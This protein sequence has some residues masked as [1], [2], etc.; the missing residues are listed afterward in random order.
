MQNE[1][2]TH[3]ISTKRDGTMSPINGMDNREKYFARQNVSLSREVV[4]TNLVHGTNVQIVDE[5]QA[6]T[7]VKET[8]GVITNEKNLHLSV[9]AGDCLPLFFTDM[10]NRVIGIAHAGWRGVV[11]EIALKVVDTMQK[12]FGT[13]P[14]N[15]QILIGPHIKQCHFEVQEDIIGLFSDYPEAIIH[16]KKGTH[17]NLAMIVMRQLLERGVK[18]GNMKVSSSCTYCCINYFSNR[19]D[20]PD[21]ITSQIAHIGMI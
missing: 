21:I 6:G 14:E 12:G 20:Q 5:E 9:G 3:G 15:I 13:D 7:I 19:R 10:K 11:G 8:D 1:D 2:I 17:V 16:L 4:C 18:M